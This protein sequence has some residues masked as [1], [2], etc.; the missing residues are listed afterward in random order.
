MA[1]SFGAS[2]ILSA[3]G[4]D[5]DDWEIQDTGNDET[6]D[7]AVVKTKE[8]AYVAASDKAFNHRT[9]KTIT[10]KPKDPDGVTASFTL[11]GAGTAGVVITQFNAKQ[12]NNDYGTL[13]VTAHQHDSDDEHLALPLAQAIS[14]TLGFGILENYLG[15]AIEDCQSV[16]LSGSCEHV[17]KLGNQGEF[18]VGASTGLRFECTEEYVDE[19]SNVSVPS[20]WFQ[21]S[22]AVNS[23][24]EDFVSR[25]IKAHAYALA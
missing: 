11:G 20:G 10:L 8:G 19:G 17:D 16:D 14:I 18:L 3:L 25:S 12:V 23:G 13:S 15:G 2:D 6:N 9:E 7:T 5:A 22:Q 24:N 21:D 4:I 1:K